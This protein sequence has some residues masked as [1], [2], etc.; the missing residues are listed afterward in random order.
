[1]TCV[2]TPYNL[3]KYFPGCDFAYFAQDRQNLCNHRRSTFQIVRIHRCLYLVLLRVRCTDWNLF[4]PT[5]VLYV[6]LNTLLH[7]LIKQ[8]IYTKFSIL[9]PVCAKV[10]AYECQWVWF[11]VSWDDEIFFFYLFATSHQ[12]LLVLLNHAYWTHYTH[13][14]HISCYWAQASESAADT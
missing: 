4:I 9:G 2:R 12:S 1:M 11:V 8:S 6:M 3:I 10:F 5:I 13:I 7:S 14:M